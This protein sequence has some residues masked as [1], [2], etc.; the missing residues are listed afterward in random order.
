M[1][2]DENILRRLRGDDVG[3]ATLALPPCLKDSPETI[4]TT[5]EVAELGR[6][7]FT[8]RRFAERRFGRYFWTCER[9]EL[10]DRAP[11]DAVQSAPRSTSTAS[12]RR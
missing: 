2:L 6:V 11:H 1:R 5:L 8:F 4:E 9:A 12:P 3:R 10:E 7:R